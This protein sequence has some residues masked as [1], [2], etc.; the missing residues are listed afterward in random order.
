[1]E[2]TLQPLLEP[3][4]FVLSEVKRERL[5]VIPPWLNALS[6]VSC[7]ASNLRLEV[8]SLD[9]TRT[10]CMQELVLRII[11]SSI[12]SVDKLFLEHVTTRQA[13]GMTR[14]QSYDSLSRRLA[15]ISE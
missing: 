7:C 1:M 10:T 4:D 13:V 11:T 8:L 6:S 3:V 5:L 2:V 14:R 9:E 12:T 15:R